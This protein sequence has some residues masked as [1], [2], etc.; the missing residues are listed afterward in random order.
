MQQRA[1]LLLIEDN[2]GDA[3]L[4]R[5]MFAEDGSLDVKLTQVGSMREAETLLARASWTSSCWTWDSPTPRGWG[6]CSVLMRRRP[7][8]L[9]WC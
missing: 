9:W 8:F 3:R 5:E 6:P 1:R 4:L 2:L 7:A